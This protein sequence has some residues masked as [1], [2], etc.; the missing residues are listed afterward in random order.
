HRQIQ[1]R[2]VL[3]VKATDGGVMDGL[4]WL[5]KS[6]T[7]NDLVV[8]YVGC[9]GSTDPEQGWVVQT[10]DGKQLWGHEIKAQLAGLPCQVLLLI[11]TCT[12]GGFTRPHRNDRPVPANVTALC[13]CSGRQTTDNQLD[14]AVA[15]ALNARADFN[16]DGVVDLDELI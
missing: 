16:K 12:S 13:A 7:R 1:S 5:R 15:E 4:G 9:H 6:T 8:M 14:M 3:G 2:L 11:E 10:A